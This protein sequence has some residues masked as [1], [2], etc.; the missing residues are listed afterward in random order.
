MTFRSTSLIIRMKLPNF[1]M[2]SNIPGEVVTVWTKPLWD[3]LGSWMSYKA[4]GVFKTKQ[5]VY[6]Y[7]SKYDVQIGAPGVGRI[8][9]K[10]LNGDNVINTADMDWQGS[11]QPKFIGWSKYRHLTKGSDLSAFFNG[12]DSRCM[13]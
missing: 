1:R 2:L 5:E 8:R 6:E 12:H 9:Y 13:E 7:L 11:D 10:D 4:D 3:N